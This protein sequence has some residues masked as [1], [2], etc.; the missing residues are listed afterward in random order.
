MDMHL[1][2]DAPWICTLIQIVNKF[3]ES[4]PIAVF[5]RL[6]SIAPTS[7]LVICTE[8]PN[9]QTNYMRIKKSIQVWCFRGSARIFFIE[10][11]IRSLL[12][13]RRE[14]DAH[15]HF[16]C[17]CV[18]LIFSHSVLGDIFIHLW[19][20]FL[21]IFAMCEIES[22]LWPFIWP[23]LIERFLALTRSSV[24][25]YILMKIKIKAVLNRNNDMK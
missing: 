23:D 7:R 3:I 1:E 2:F 25:I 11:W 15:A 4:V 19:R 16:V 12:F 22:Q 24:F 9:Y 5:V 14:D 20:C 6:L 18:L 17:K 21:L 10:V 13:T 8:N